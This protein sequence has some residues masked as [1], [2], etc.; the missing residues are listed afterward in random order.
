MHVLDDNLAD[1]L[2]RVR[3]VALD[4]DG[5]LY[6]GETVFEW[7]RPFLATLAELGIGWTYLTNNCSRSVRQYVEHLLELGLP[8]EPDQVY[9]SAPAAVEYLR[10]EQPH[11]HKLF[12]LGTEG[13]AEDFRNAGYQLVETN[14][15]GESSAGEEPDLV[16]CGFD[17]A[18]AYPRLC[19]A[20]WWIAR[21]TPWLATH[22]DGFCPTDRSTRLV[23]CGAV[24]AALTAA[25]GVEPLAVPGKPEPRMLVGLAQRI[26]CTT[27]ELAMVGDR[28]HTDMAMAGS[29]GALG[30]LVMTGDCDTERLAATDP[31][32]PLV[33]EHLGELDRLLREARNR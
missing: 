11:A 22:P 13:T 6:R 14:V 26:G 7:T 1:R 29:A 25:T 12:L 19:R 9:T 20:A 21:G 33:V 8:A 30:V 5:T 31:K 15:D 10:S 23:D 4:M 16:V 3:H 2:R 27:G 32:P 18:L 17:P 28:L 24:A